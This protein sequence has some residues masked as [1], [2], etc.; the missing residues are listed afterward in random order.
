MSTTAISETEVRQFIADWFASLDIYASV[1]EVLPM[2]ANENLVMKLPE[3][4]AY[5]HQG[6]IEM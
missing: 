1:E 4:T 2:V 5:G 3:V 6:L